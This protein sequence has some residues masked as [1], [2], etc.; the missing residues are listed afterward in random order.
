VPVG[1][2]GG[3]THSGSGVNPFFLKGGVIDCDFALRKVR[4][5]ESRVLGVAKTCS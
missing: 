4:G 5:P 1:L 3:S 2:S